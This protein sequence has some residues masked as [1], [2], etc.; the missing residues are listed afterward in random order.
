LLLIF[1]LLRPSCSKAEGRASYTRPTRVE[2]KWPHVDQA[3]CVK[4]VAAAAG[5]V[6]GLLLGPLLPLWLR[7][8]LGTCL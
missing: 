4:A 1:Q 7:Q 2:G 3:A 8:V 6:A 5:I